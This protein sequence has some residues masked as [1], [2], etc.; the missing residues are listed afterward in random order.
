[1]EGA[2]VLFAMSDETPERDF[3]GAQ[4]VVGGITLAGIP[5]LLL[6]FIQAAL[7]PEYFWNYAQ[8]GFG[9]A[10]VLLCPI[11]FGR[12]L[13]YD[14][15]LHLHGATIA[16]QLLN[17]CWMSG[18][19]NSV[20]L[21]VFPIV[22][23]Y[24]ATIGKPR[25]VLGVSALLVLDAFFIWFGSD[26][27]WIEE[28][29]LKSSFFGIA[30]LIWSMGT[31]G[32][33][34]LHHSS[35]ENDLLEQTREESERRRQSQI[36]VEQSEKR[37]AEVNASKSAFLNYLA[38]E[39]RNPLTAIRGTAELISLP[40][41]DAAAR[42]ISVRPIHQGVESIQQLLNQ[43]LEF[44]KAEGQEILP[45]WEGVELHPFYQ[46]LVAHG[47]AM[48]SDSPLTFKRIAR[49]PPVAWRGDP[50]LTRQILA[51][52]LDNAFKYTESGWVEF[53]MTVE[54]NRI[55]CFAVEDTGV[56]IAKERV[57]DIFKPFVRLENPERKPVRGAGL[58]LAIV[59][60]LVR[61]IQGT[62][63][64]EST[65][66]SGTTVQLKLPLLPDESIGKVD[67]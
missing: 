23:I 54:N 46:S 49:V 48:S 24:I 30:V 5:L 9:H 56:G 31:A 3:Q 63:H 41:E 32:W 64:V 43:V 6:I 62:L 2:R 35:L 15:L 16:A 25:A 28:D 61:S 13:S 4:I 47:I 59:Q 39:L 1:M 22:P 12:F 27:G 45:K 44:G 34:A 29:S 57:E 8:V 21:F 20:V 14:R 17:A 55:L 58:G 60:Q 26:Q 50:H 42:P 40:A 38:H 51:N 37:L 18:G 65:P 53:R 66:G 11:L 52:L 19:S 7:E 67:V 33:I 10:V 36:R